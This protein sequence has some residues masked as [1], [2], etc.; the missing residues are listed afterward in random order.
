MRATPIVHRV[1]VFVAYHGGGETFVFQSLAKWGALYLNL[2]KYIEQA[3]ST[4]GSTD[5]WARYTKN[6]VLETWRSDDLEA[7]ELRHSEIGIPSSDMPMSERAVLPDI[8]LLIYS[9]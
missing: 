9:K 8:I 4:A 6:S 2:K 3:E 5:Q 7:S 1:R